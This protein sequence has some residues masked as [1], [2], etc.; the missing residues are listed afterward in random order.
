MDHGH[1]SIPGARVLFCSDEHITWVPGRGEGASEP[2][3]SP[4]DWESPGTARVG[5]RIR[6]V[7]AHVDPTLA[8]HERLYVVDGEDLVDEWAIDLRGW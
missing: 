6:I 2:F 3:R 7:P 1:P 4:I 5:D 8:Y